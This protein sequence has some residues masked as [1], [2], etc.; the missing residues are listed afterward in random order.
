MP[1]RYTDY[2]RV[3][4]RAEVKQVRAIAAAAAARWDP[5]AL[6]TEQPNDQ[7]IGPILEDVEAADRSPTYKSYCAQCKSVAVRN[8]ILEHQ[9][10]STDGR[11]KIAQIVLPRSRVNEVLTELHDGQSGSHLGVNKTLNKV[12]Q[13]YYWLQ[14]QSDVKM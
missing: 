10:E 14:A 1:R 4:V 11:S 7:D 8:G 5:A 13:K 12:R 3:E 9:W 6:G 2:H